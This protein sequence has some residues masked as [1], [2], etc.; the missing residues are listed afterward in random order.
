MGEGLHNGSLQQGI[1][2]TIIFF[3]GSVFLTFSHIL[4]HVLMV[5]N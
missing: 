2:K 1:L 5:Y 4:M 3:F